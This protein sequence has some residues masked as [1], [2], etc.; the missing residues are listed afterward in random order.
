MTINDSLRAGLKFIRDA[1]T[2][3]RHASG[4]NPGA[5]HHKTIEGLASR[6]LIEKKG[7]GYVITAAGR[8]ALAR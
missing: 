8:A 1:K 6:F 7:D 4:A 3:V 2:P 5:P